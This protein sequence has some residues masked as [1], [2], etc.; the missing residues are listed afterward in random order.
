MN[1][2]I[3]IFYKFA[4]F[5]LLVFPCRNAFSQGREVPILSVLLSDSVEV[6]DSCF[7]TAIFRLSGG[8]PLTTETIL[9]CDS[10]Y[11]FLKQNPSVN[12]AIISHSD[13]RPIP[14]TNDTLTM[15]RA[16]RLKDEILKYGDIDP[17]RIIAIG[18]GDKQPRVV[19][20]ELHKQYK[21]LPVG[22]VLD[23][24]FC[25]TLFSNKKDYETAVSLNRRAVVKVV[26]K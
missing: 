2:Q 23:M 3:N 13:F 6:G 1:K 8:S 18:M 21:F 11:L 5:L 14:M 26:G 19:T 17:D 12:I 15:R 25:K 20:K 10:I 9:A 16:N 4:M 22:Q 24:E 7:F